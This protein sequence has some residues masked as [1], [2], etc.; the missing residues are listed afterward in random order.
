MENVNLEEYIYKFNAICVII[1]AFLNDSLSLNGKIVW[2][3][4]NKKSTR[5]K[6][7]LW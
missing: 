4:N 2:I 5:P 7:I 1:Q 3:Y 6:H